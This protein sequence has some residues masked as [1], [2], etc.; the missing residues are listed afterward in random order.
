MKDKKSPLK[1]KGLAAGAYA[2]AE[3]DPKVNKKI[4]AAQ[5]ASRIGQSIAG[6]GLALTQYFG[7]IGRQ[8]DE[9]VENVTNNGVMLSDENFES[10]YD[11][12]QSGRNKFILGNKKNRTL[13]MKD[14]NSLA[15]SYEDYKNLVENTAI[16]A[17][18]PDGLLDVFKN[19]EEGKMYLDAVS[20]KNKLVKNPNKDAQ[21]PNDLGVL[22]NGTWRS[23]NDLKRIADSNIKDTGFM[24]TIEALAVKQLNRKTPPNMK[25]IDYTVS[26][27]VSNGKTKSLVHSEIIPGRTFYDDLVTKLTK[28]NY[29]DLGLN[30]VSLARYANVNKVNTKDGID[31]EEARLIANTMI[32]DKAYGNQLNNEL[33]EYYSNYVAQQN[34][35]Y[36]SLFPPAENDTFNA[37]GD[38]GRTIEDYNQ[39]TEYTQEQISSVMD[40]LKNNE[41]DETEALNFIEK[42]QQELADM[43]GAVEKARKN[44]QLLN[45]AFTIGGGLLGLT[46]FGR[47]FQLARLTGKSLMKV[48]RNRAVI[49]NFLRK[50]KSN[51]KKKNYN[52]NALELPAPGIS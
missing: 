47:G 13:V 20:G 14:L 2:A 45:T 16:L 22:V 35:Q 41:I 43:G 50:A 52:F 46:V 33:T 40:A 39:F 30:D 25:V 24:S 10:L 27:M 23:M 11:E 26:R 3:A 9:F 31:A 19:S 36:A 44:N 6:T 34:P 1:F 29:T 12:L 5:Q 51:I 17:D 38:G 28:Q 18:S 4:V 8:Y 15:N 37:P 49:L 7:E 48:Y 32:N 42:F 21:N